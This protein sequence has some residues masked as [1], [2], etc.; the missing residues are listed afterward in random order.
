MAKTTTTKSTTGFSFLD[1]DKSL[2]KISGF[3]TGSILTTNTFSEV[4][5]WIPT[6]NFLLNAQI[7]GTLFGGVPNNRSFG[8][9]GDPGT[10]KSF[11]CL[12]VV[13]EAQKIGYDVIYCDSEGAIDKSGALK[14]GIDTDKIRYQPIKTVSQFQTFVSNL[15]ELVNKA[16]AAGQQPKILIVL[17]SLGML[18]TDKELADA[19]KGHNASDMGAKAKE[20]RKLFR[21]ITLDLTAAKIP[22]IC[23]NHVYAGGGAYIPTKESSGGDGPI[24][25]MS[26]VAFLSKAQL[27]DGAGTKTGIVVTSTLKKSRFTIPEPVK[28]HISFANGMNPYVGLQDYVSWEACGVERGKFEEVKNA[29]GKKESVFKPSASSTRWGVRHLGKTVASTELFTDK[30]FTQEVLEQ[31]DKNVIQDKFK[32][33]DLPDHDELLSTLDEEGVI[34]DSEEDDE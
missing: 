5:E 22:L 24:F 12:N 6:G 33:P 7:S 29:D 26:V 19:L 16:K 30:V 15:M 32:F 17:D 27:K 1:L 8:V 20:L 23:T 9:M 2:S 13:R 10:G 31:L 3:E 11:F 21:V 34:L 4:D 25:A 28:F 14:F 18:S